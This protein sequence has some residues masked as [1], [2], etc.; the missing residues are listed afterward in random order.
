VARRRHAPGSAGRAQVRR[1]A[2][3]ARDARGSRD[4]AGRRIGLYIG[5]EA[6]E[7]LSEAHK[8][9][10][11]HRDI[12]P[13]NVLC[14]TSGRVKVADFGL[15]R[16]VEAITRTHTVWAHHTPLYA[17]PEQWDD[18]KPD[19]T[20]DVYQLCATIYH[21]PAGQPANQGKNMAGLFR[22][23]QTAVATPL[24][25]LAPNLN[26]AVSDVIMQGLG[27]NREDRPEP[28]RVFDALSGALMRR[29]NLH[30]DVTGCPDDVV[31][32][33]AKLT[34][35]DHEEL[36]DGLVAEIEFANPIEALKEALGVVVLGAVAAITDPEPEP[37]PEPESEP[38]LQATA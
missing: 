30:V 27:K 2:A 9:G 23:H 1:G 34:E 32:A 12:K 18:E 35:F 21:V 22:R 36:K 6:T 24:A 28:W 37:E 16:V 19:V 17:A 8:I 38:Q 10:I 13:Q 11:L 15:A 25:D 4:P 3:P 31:R 14:A 7:A 29:T 20:T 33:V 5:L 26:S